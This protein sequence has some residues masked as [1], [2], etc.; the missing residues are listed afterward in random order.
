MKQ[1]KKLKLDYKMALS[2][3]N[4]NPNDWMLLKDGDTYITIDYTN[5]HLWYYKNGKLKAESDIVSGNINRQNGSVDGIFKIVYKQ[6]NATL[7]GED[8]NTLVK[9]FMPFAYNIGIHD[10]GWRSSF[11]DEI[12]KTSGSHGCINIPPKMAKKLYEKIENGTPVIA[13]YR[14]KVELT[15]TAAQVSNAYSYVEKKDKH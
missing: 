4:L 8:Y 5:Q 10:A 1:P 15:N 6:K 9:Y 11:G 2:A 14:E 7:V 13:Y 3:Y 12:Y